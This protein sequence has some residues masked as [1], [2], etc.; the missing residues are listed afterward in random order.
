VKS[1]ILAVHEW[2]KGRKRGA[3]FVRYADGILE[4]VADLK[5][6]WCKPLGY[7]TGSLG[8]FVGENILGFARVADWFYSPLH[9]IGSDPVYTPP[10]HG[11]EWTGAQCKDYCKVRC[12]GEEDHKLN[13]GIERCVGAGVYLFD[14]TRRLWLCGAVCVVVLDVVTV[15]VAIKETLTHDLIFCLPPF[16]LPI[17]ADISTTDFQ[18]VV[19]LQS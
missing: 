14:D 11:R 2:A 10:A 9:E 13:T 6:D 4:G 18:R 19:L 1:S 8:G 5:L 12:N 17:S 15:V 16:S 3:T 7:R